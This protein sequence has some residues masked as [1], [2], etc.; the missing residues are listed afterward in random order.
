LSIIKSLPCNRRKLLELHFW[1]NRYSYII[2]VNILLLSS[3]KVLEYYFKK[4]VYGDGISAVPPDEYADRF[5]RF[6]EDNVF[7]LP[8]KQ[9]AVASRPKN[10]Y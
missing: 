6:I 5:S 1:Y 7:T 2:R 9:K 10:N 4:L 3:R 8:E